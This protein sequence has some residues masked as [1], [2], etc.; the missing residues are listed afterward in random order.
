MFSGAVL[1][2]EQAV[3]SAHFEALVVAVGALPTDIDRRQQS[4]RE[5]ECHDDVVE[6]VERADFRHEAGPVRE[7]LIRRR[8]RDVTD[9]VEVVHH[10][11]VEDPA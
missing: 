6:I 11:I 1:G 8:A 2:F 7:H 4:V 3:R 9:E 5:T 10:A